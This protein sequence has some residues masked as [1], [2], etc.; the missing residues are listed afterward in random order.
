MLSKCRNI[1]KIY[2]N[3]C[4]VLFIYTL[5]YLFPYLFMHLFILLFV[6]LFQHLFIYVFIYSCIYFVIYL[7]LY[8][9][10]Y[11]FIYSCISSYIYLHIYLF[12]L[13]SCSVLHRKE[14]MERNEAWLKCRICLVFW[15]KN[16]IYILYIGMA[17]QYIVQI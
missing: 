16:Y 11:L 4:S 10:T 8:L 2:N 6:Y 9:F 7:F 15:K 1:W 14:Q 12:I 13:K 17:L 3:V 5:V